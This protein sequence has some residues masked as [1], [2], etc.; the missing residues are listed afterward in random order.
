MPEER[1]D[2]RG[3]LADALSR[4]SRP[5][6]EETLFRQLRELE[7]GPLEQLGALVGH[8]IEELRVAQRRIAEQAGEL[9][10]L[11]RTVAALTDRVD[12]LTAAAPPAAP[13]PEP[14]VGH[15]LLAGG[16]DGYVLVAADGPPPAPGAEVSIGGRTWTVL[17]AGRSPLP[18]DRRPCVLALPR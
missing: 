4:R 15:L 17:G 16:A 13:A 14:V 6:L 7:Q 11:A 3:W 10:A 18:G 2:V 12:S 9:R 8:A 1:P 5:A